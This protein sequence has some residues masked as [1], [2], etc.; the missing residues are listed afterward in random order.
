MGISIFPSQGGGYTLQRVITTTG[1][2]SLGA[3]TACF[4]MMTGGGGGGGGGAG[5][6]NS[7]AG[8]GGGGAG[9]FAISTMLSEFHAT[10]GAGGTGGSP[11]TNDATSGGHSALTVGGG[12]EGIQNTISQPAATSAKQIVCRGGG[13]GN[14]VGAG[15]AG[16][17]PATVT[18]ITGR[19]PDWIYGSSGSSG[20]GYQGQ[21]YPTFVGAWRTSASQSGGYLAHN[22]FHNNSSNWVQQG[23]NASQVYTGANFN[24]FLLFPGGFNPSNNFNPNNSTYQAQ[25]THMTQDTTAGRGVACGG[26]GAWNS[27]STGGAKGGAGLMTG[28]GGGGGYSNTLGANSG[29]ATLLY[30]GGLGNTSGG[31][32]GG[33]AGIFGSGTNGTFTSSAAGGNGGA[34]GLGGGGGG[35]GGGGTSSSGTGGAG[36]AGI[37]LIFY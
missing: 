10:I 21:T 30:N 29:G 28:G 2:Y 27:S 8:G 20:G 11:N 34:G 25:F 15:T 36:G 22:I 37:M 23:A 6:T 18:G 5:S 19:N 4:V 24:S 26:E 13:A 7:S 33:G 3:P 35:G 1:N 32:A 16:S 31:G 17:Q 9:A 12:N 14:G